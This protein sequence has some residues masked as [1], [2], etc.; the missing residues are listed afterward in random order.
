NASSETAAMPT[1]STA[2]EP[3]SQSSQR[4]RMCM[5]PPIFPC[6]PIAGA[7]HSP[8]AALSSHWSR[9]A[10]SW[11]K[12]EDFGSFL[13]LGTG[14]RTGRNEPVPLPGKQISNNAVETVK[15]CCGA[16]EEIGALGAGRALAQK[17]ARV[18]EHWIG[19]GALV[20]REIALEHRTR[21]PE[22]VDAGF[23]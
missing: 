20:D 12:C 16:G 21:S 10:V 7:I 6:L 5:A 18:P 11:F 2:S 3:R 9:R 13:A 14:R 23:Q 19:V 15:S 22:G 8:A 17:L 1:I 4:L